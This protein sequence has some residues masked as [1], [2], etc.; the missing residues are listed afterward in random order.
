ME[1][2]KMEWLGMKRFKIITELFAV[3][4]VLAVSVLAVSVL[5]GTDAYAQ[6]GSPEDPMVSRSYVNSRIAE[7]ELQIAHL[8]A[9]I[10]DLDQGV[11]VPVTAPGQGHDA[12]IVSRE[13]FVVV[14]A[15]PGMTLIGAA[16]TEIILRAGRATVVAGENGLANVTTGRDLMNGESVPLNNLLIVPQPDGRGMRFYADS[17]LM[18]KGDFHLV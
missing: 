18:I 9:I 6:P 13:L 17:Y 16:S 14:R 3:L 4:S 12:P 1:W 5:V 11:S 2:F 10:E 15:E 7:L 8:I